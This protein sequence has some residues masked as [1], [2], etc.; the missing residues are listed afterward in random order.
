MTKLTFIKLKLPWQFDHYS[1]P[2]LGLL[3]VASEARKIGGLEVSLTD[4]AHETKIPES[5]LY[6]F[7]AST[8]EFPEA[9]KKAAEIKKQYPDSK[10]LVGGPHFDITPE[11]DWAQSIDGSDFDVICRG[12]GEAN[13]NKAVNY[14]MENPDKKIVISQ[15]TP[16]IQLDSLDTPARDLLDKEKYFKPGKTFGTGEYSDGNSSTIMVSRGCPYICSFC[17][18]PELHKRKVRFRSFD[19]IKEELSE[20]QDQYGVSE[21]RWQDDCIPLVLKRA[22]GLDNLLHGNGIMSRGSMRTDQV[23]GESLHQLWYSG[24]RELGFGI[25]SAEDG[26]LDL[27]NKRTTVEK[28][29]YALKMTKDKGFR[30]RAFIMTGLPGESAHSAEKMIDFL[31]KTKPDVVTL[32]SFIPLP[33]CDIYNNPDKYGVEILTKDWSKY[34]IAL[35][36]N[37]GT[38]WAHKTSSTTLPKMEKNREMLKEYLFNNGMSN[39]SVFNKVYESDKL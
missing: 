27:L 28:N 30:T 10:I 22:K 1:D 33:G 24:F 14:A 9:Q 13:V 36:W 31:E 19:K 37:S 18:S 23:T 3:S 8:L 29:A 26:V 34:D 17:A 5:E 21:L 32:T 7:S 15:K 6:A 12:E 16:L 20:L 4:L 38:E 2:P 11:R 25:E 35:K 39:V